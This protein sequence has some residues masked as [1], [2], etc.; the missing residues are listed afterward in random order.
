MTRPKFFRDPIHLQIRF[1]PFDGTI[2]PAT[3]PREPQISWALQEL[4]DSKPLQRL[5]AIRQNGLANYVF[6]GAE[7]SRFAHS[8]GVSYLARIMFERLCRNMSIEEVQREKLQVSVASL[9]H[10][11]GHGPFSHTL[12]EILKEANIEFHHETMTRRMIEE[13]GGAIYEIL[14]KI[15]DALPQEVSLFFRKKKPEEHWKYRIISSQMD[16]DRLDYS[17]RDA[18]FSG[19]KGHG[20]DLERLLDLI[21]IHEGTSIAVDRTGLSA[22]EAYLVTL[23]HLWRSIY[24]HQGVRAATKMLTSLFRRAVFLHRDGIPDIFPTRRQGDFHPFAL[25]LEKGNEIDLNEY[26]RLTDHVVWELL[27][28]WARHDDFVLSDLSNR[29]VC[30]KLLKAMPVDLSDLEAVFAFKQKA[31]EETKKVLGRHADMQ[32]YY[33]LLD[34]PDRTSYKTYNWKPESQIESIW[35]TGGGK[36]DT[37]IEDGEESRMIV[38]L[39]DARKF[40]RYLMLPEVRDSLV[41]S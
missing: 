30:R 23:D 15:D 20:F 9:V 29:I 8:M 24:Y 37:P 13:E 34:G 10:D 39:K 28:Y 35:L 31:E 38:A 26:C 1:D 6:H 22:V 40:D 41:Q 4:I 17:H 3:L 32:E 27:D 12:E 5:R 25:L 21:F 2:E 16:A 36:D 18:Q 11:V 14:S 19:I 7:H 33:L